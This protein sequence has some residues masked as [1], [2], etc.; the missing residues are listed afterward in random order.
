MATDWQRLAAAR[1]QAHLGAEWVSRCA[2]FLAEPQ[3]SGEHFA[4]RWESGN[5]FLSVPFA[6][7]EGGAADM[8]MRFNL[9]ELCLEIDRQRRTGRQYWTLYMED[10]TYEEVGRAVEQALCK[11]G[12]AAERA[13]LIQGALPYSKQ[14]PHTVQPEFVGAGRRFSPGEQAGELAEL[15]GWFSLAQLLLAEKWRAVAADFLPTSG[16]LCW[17]HHFDLAV[18][19]NL[20]SERS[21]G[22]GLSPGD[23]VIETPYF[24][25]NV[26][27]WPGAAGELPTVPPELQGVYWHSEGFNSLVLRADAVPAGSPEGA[28]AEAF[29]RR[30][31]DWSVQSLRQLLAP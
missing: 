3:Q 26:W 13:A 23:G 31:L 24:Y 29:V 14:P 11:L 12:M 15:E 20:D 17:P 28:E 7:E 30:Y 1:V 16:P 21:I 10:R 5:G 18:L 2:R 22:M 27:P 25:M 8:R 9:R 6:C 19:L 4:L